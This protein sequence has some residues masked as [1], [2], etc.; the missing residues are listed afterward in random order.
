MI[1]EKHNVSA[2]FLWETNL[3]CFRI[4]YFWSHTVKK[5]TAFLLFVSK[6][7]AA[8]PLSFILLSK[9]DKEMKRRKKKDE[10]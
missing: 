5:V 6:T 9:K 1:Y 4:F 7:R 8:D 10:G 3:S 2:S